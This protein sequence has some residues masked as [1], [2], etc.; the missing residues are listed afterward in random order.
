MNNNITDINAKIRNIKYEPLLCSELTSFDYSDLARALGDKAA[1]FLDVDEQNTFAISRWVSPKRTRS[2]PY[3]RVYDTLQFSGKRVTII[4][5]I[6]DE[7]QHGDR[8]YLQ[9]DTVS[10]MSLL[11]V[12]VLIGYYVIA[13]PNRRNPKKPK[14]TNQQFD[15]D[16][17]KNKIDELLSYQSDALHWNLSQLERIGVIGNKAIEA[18]SK[19]QKQLGIPLHSMDM[20]RMRFEEIGTDSETFK[21]ASRRLA[22]SA[23]ARETQVVNPYELISGV[24]GKITI[25]NY[26]GGEYHF[27]ADEVRFIGD[28]KLEFVEAK[29]TTDPNKILTSHNDIKDA[30]FKMVLFTNLEN[31]RIDSHKYKHDSVIKLTSSRGFDIS[32][33]SNRESEFYRLLQE[34][35][36]KNNF[37]IRHE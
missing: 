32:K 8:D 33:L 26:I 6:K 35:A 36:R 4:P 34:E 19:I 11:G 7:G 20:A 18:Y 1:F 23:Q 14:I 24:K 10:L 21:Y 28:Y 9:W 3:V 22:A 37:L 15:I 12:Y 31:V 5:I 13:E 17:L 16:Y 30:L 25:T 27:T 29:N 2:Y